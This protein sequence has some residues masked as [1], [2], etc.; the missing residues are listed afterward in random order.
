MD[1]ASFN[2]EK[3]CRSFT[4][5]YLTQLLDRLSTIYVFNTNW[6]V[7]TQNLHKKQSLKD[8]TIREINA[9]ASKLK[10]TADLSR[11]VSCDITT[12][13]RLIPSSIHVC[14]T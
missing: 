9:K 10:M 5:A 7:F 3:C 14:G 4:L 6:N 11:D 13:I 1:Q 2:T 8:S 12:R